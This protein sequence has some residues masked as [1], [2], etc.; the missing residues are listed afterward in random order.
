MDG[1]TAYPATNREKPTCRPASGIS[2]PNLN[3]KLP[4]RGKGVRKFKLTAEKNNHTQNFSGGGK[5]NYNSDGGSTRDN[6]TNDG[7]RKDGGC[8]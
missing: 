1:A 4:S 5:Y 7:N 2:R 3:F 6:G 8:R